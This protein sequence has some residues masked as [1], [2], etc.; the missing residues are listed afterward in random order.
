[1]KATTTAAFLGTLTLFLCVSC[2]SDRTAL[3]APN[4]AVGA[5]S[6]VND[7]WEPYNRSVQAFNS[8]FEQHV[9]NPVSQ[10][11]RFALPSFVRTGLSHFN[12]NIGYPL[13][14]IAHALEGNWEYCWYDTKRFAINTTIGG[15]GL[16]DPATSLGLPHIDGSF[17]RTLA[18]WGIPSGGYFNLPFAGPGTVRDGVGKILDFPFNLITWLVPAPASYAVNGAFHINDTAETEPTV[19]RAFTT[20]P[21]HYELMKLLIVL[22]NEATYSDYKIPPNKDYLPDQSFGLLQLAPSDD[23]F[24]YQARQRHVKLS[25]GRK[26]PYTCWPLRNAKKLVILLPGIGAHRQSAELSAFAEFFRRRDCAVIAISST[27]TPDYFTNVPGDNPPPGFIPED[28]KVLVHVLNEVVSDFTCHYGYF[29]DTT[30]LLG[31]S[32]GGINALNLAAAEQRGEFPDTLHI[33]RYLAINPPV[34]PVYALDVVDKFFN[35]P[36]QF[37]EAEREARVRDIIMRLASWMQPS[38]INP[39]SL[40]VP[41]THEESQFLVGV[42]MRFHLAEAIQAQEKR[43][44][45]GLLHEDPQAW[46]HRNNLFAETMSISFNDYIEKMVVP[47]YQAHGL[48]GCTAEDLR[49]KCSLRELTDDLART[50]NVLVFHS[51]NDFLVTDED[52]SWFE[53]T[54]GPRATILD[55]GSH[56]GALGNRAFVQNLVNALLD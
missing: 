27:F 29:F 55:E 47:Y 39:P 30:T 18:K 10:L 35:Y 13:R 8:G 40:V 51:R 3:Y 42:N 4:G 43:N 49:K 32:L 6:P 12:E 48:D 9:A 23:G 28:A 20:Q 36:E 56:L 22:G 1:L 50:K 54:F 34:D 37:P 53:A 41:L 14:L 7:S 46:F 33:D 31:Y 44:P 2:V 52:L 21:C 38:P 25:R 17:G 24:Y 45:S 5:L 15:L 16:W 19:N 11:W 26:F